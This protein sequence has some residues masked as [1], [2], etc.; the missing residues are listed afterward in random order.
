MKLE[1]TLTDQDYIN[2]NL[3]FA[4]TSSTV[5]KSMLRARLTGPVL[6]LALPFVLQN[7]SDIPFI[8]WMSVM[9][10]T[11]VGWFFF[12][13][14]LMKRSTIR[15]VRKILKERGESF[16]GPKT[17]ELTD[18]GIITRGTDSAS[19]TAYSAIQQIVPYKGGLYLYTGALAAIMIAPNAF[20]SDAHRNEFI[21]A[22]EARLPQPLP[23]Q[24]ERK[25]GIF[26]KMDR[27]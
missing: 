24:A 22:L 13:P 17:L 14:S 18:G 4:E 27:L 6:F 10:F 23:Q 25:A 12:L 19:T 26:D 7:V 2:F 11:A 3:S 21:Q 1:Y 15:S 9:G 8:Y 5:K 16:L 20:T